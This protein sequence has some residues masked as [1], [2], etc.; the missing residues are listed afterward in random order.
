MPFQQN[1]EV[2]VLRY[3]HLR[4]FPSLKENLTIFS[5]AQSKLPNGQRGHV[6]S[7]A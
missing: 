7:F 2:N 5:A 1:D 6:K 4:E 3:D